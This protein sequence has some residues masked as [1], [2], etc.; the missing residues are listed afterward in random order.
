VADILSLAQDLYDEACEDNALLSEYRTERKSLLAGIRAGTGT[1]DVV[2][3]TKNG[4]SYTRR[5]G[6]SVEDR[7]SALRYA[8]QGIEAATR[9]GHT[10]RKFFT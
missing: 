4:A 1:G 5:V 2:S 9:P 6:F 7:L 8:I 3:G 10:S